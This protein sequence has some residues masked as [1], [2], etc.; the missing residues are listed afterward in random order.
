VLASAALAANHS[1]F[2]LQR[3]RS[4]FSGQVPISRD[5]SHLPAWYNWDEAFKKAD[6]S[7]KVKVHVRRIGTSK[8]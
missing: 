2:W 1:V 7:Y 6:I 3:K 5:V 4:T 8:K